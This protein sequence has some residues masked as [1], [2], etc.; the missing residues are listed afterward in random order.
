[1]GVH[2]AKAT[3]LSWARQLHLDPELRRIQGH[4]RGSGSDLSLRL[5]SRDDIAP[6]ILLQR[7]IIDRIRS[8]FR[9][10]QSLHRGASAPLL[11]FPLSLPA[12]L[13]GPVE[14]NTGHEPQPADDYDAQQLDE[15]EPLADDHDSPAQVS[16]GD[17]P[18]SDP[19]SGGSCS[20]SDD[21]APP[22]ERPALS[23]APG[24]TVYLLHPRSRVLHL[25]MPCSL[26]DPRGVLITFGDGSEAIF[27]PACGAES[28]LLDSASLYTAP[29]HRCCLCLRR[30]CAAA[31]Q[32]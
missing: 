9:P 26:R 23:S 19:V 13:P 32:G 30:A 25:A 5:Y 20:S 22:V 29:P 28:A 1:M 15:P 10:L 4:H 24:R 8:G 6:M 27:K 16:S 31:F 17:S 14:A 12:A 18:L 2:S 3:V 11:D 7:Q 21:D